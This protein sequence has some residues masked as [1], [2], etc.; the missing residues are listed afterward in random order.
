VVYNPLITGVQK[1]FPQGGVIFLHILIGFKGAF[2]LKS[3][4]EACLEKNPDSHVEV[5]DLRPHFLTPPH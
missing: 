4:S 1:Q 3:T 5:L 2:Q